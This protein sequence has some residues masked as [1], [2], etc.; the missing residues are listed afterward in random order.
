MLAIGQLAAEAAYAAM[1]PT[2]A[3]AYAESALAALSERRDRT[4]YAVLQARLGR[5][6]VAAG[7]A[8]GATSA[9]RKAA[10]VAPREPSIER[11]RILALLAQERMIAG[12]FSD[13]ERAASEALEIARGLGEPTPSPRRSTR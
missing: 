4:A 5:Y 8:A 6:R 7:D 2:R 9:L 11:A 13:S 1:R 12:A 10:G 3:V